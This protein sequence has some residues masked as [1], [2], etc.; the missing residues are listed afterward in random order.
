LARATTE[1]KQI[2]IASIKNKKG[3]ILMSGDS[4]SDAT[5]LK[6]ANVG[7]SMGSGCSVAKENSDL[8]ILDNDFKSIHSAIMWGRTIFYNIK[9]FI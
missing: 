3:W 7:I 1:D 5:A 2:L 9:K 4:S 8:V 6:M